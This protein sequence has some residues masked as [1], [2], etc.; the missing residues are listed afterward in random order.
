MRIPIV[1]PAYEPDENLI[2]LCNKLID[3]KLNDI[4][5]VDDGS[6]SEYQAIFTEVQAIKGVT[7]LVHEVNRG[8]GRALKTAFEYL[9]KDEEVV[10]CVTADSDG[11]HSVTDIMKCI[12][13]LKA[14]PTALILGCRNF[15]EDNVPNRSK[16]GNK[17]TR[18][19]CKLMTGVDVSDTQTGLRAIPADYMVELINTAGERFEFET[20]MLIDAKKRMPILEV[21]IETIYESKTDHKS[22]YNTVKDSFRISLIFGRIFFKFVLSSGTSCILDLGIFTLLCAMLRDSGI[23]AYVAVSTVIA[24]VVSATYNYLINYKLVFK[25]KEKASA[26]FAKYALLAIIQMSLSALLV[27]GGVMLLSPL[28]EVVIKLIVDTILFFISYRVQQ[29]YIF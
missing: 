5:V 10:G 6:G 11:Q 27:T 9:T 21:P 18:T 23:I 29:T 14:N 1:I 16:I 3:N 15:D 25:S 12:D 13:A 24:R 17:F 4:V 28:P 20:N 2:I 26:S 7:L 19:I 8:K 22:H